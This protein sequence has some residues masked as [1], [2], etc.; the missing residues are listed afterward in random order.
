MESFK[1]ER[2][3]IILI[4]GLL[5]NS[6]RIYLM[7]TTAEDTSQVKI[8]VTLLFLLELCYLIVIHIYNFYSVEKL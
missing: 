8:L 2:F 1:I 3:A 4:S 7:L 6:L 5:F